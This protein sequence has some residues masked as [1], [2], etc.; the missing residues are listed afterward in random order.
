MFIKIA[1]NQG[2]D[3]PVNCKYLIPL[4]VT[5]LIGVKEVGFFTCGINELKQIFE[6]IQ[7]PNSTQISLSGTEVEIP[8]FKII[9]KKR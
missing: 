3:L 5:N 2:F 7:P 8:F 1:Q 9:E 6:K 4:F